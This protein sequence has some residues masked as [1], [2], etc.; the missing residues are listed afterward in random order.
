MIVGIGDM[1]TTA[2][3]AVRCVAKDLGSKSIGTVTVLHA[4]GGCQTPQSISL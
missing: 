4:D 2:C 1:Y 3:D